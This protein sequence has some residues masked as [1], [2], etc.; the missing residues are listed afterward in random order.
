M[1]KRVLLGRSPILAFQRSNTLNATVP[2][3]N[4]HVRSSEYSDAGSRGRI[5]A[6]E[7]KTRV[8]EGCALLQKP[9]KSLA[10][11]RERPTSGR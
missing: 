1:A 10:K 11:S 8:M 2:N 6:L 9:K 7:S 4:T 3:L 5:L